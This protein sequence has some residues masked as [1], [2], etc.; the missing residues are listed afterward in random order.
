MNEILFEIGT[1]EIPSGYIAPAAEA[2]LSNVCGRLDKLSISYEDPQW[3]ATPRRLAVS[4]MG[5]PE[6]RPVKV[7]KIFGPPRKSAFNDDGSLSKAGLGFAKSKGVEPGAVKVEQTDKGEYAYV[8]IDSG[9]ELCAALM[10]EELPKAAME[11]PFPKS[12]AWGDYGFRFTRPIH[13]VV[14]VFG[15]K[16]IPFQLGHIQTGAQTRGHRFLG[17]QDMQVTGRSDY[18]VHL[19][20]AHVVA[21]LEKRKKM[22]MD[23]ARAVASAHAATLVED[24]DLAHTI[25]CLVEWP[26]ALWGS[27]DKAY[28]ALPEELLIASMKNHQ[29]MF[30]V[31]DSAGKLTNGFVGVSNMKVEDEQVVVSGYQRVLR[32]RLADAKFFFDEDL[33]KPLESFVA[34]LDHVVYQ[35]KLGTIGQKVKRFTTMAGKIAQIVDPAL[36]KNVNRAAHLCKADLE[37]L[38]VYEFPELQGVVGREYARHAGE[39]EEVCMA[40]NESYMPRFSGDKTA[41]GAVGAIVGIADRIDTLTGCFGIG[42][43][44]TGTQDPFA[45]RRGALGVIQTIL[46]KGYRISLT[47]LISTSIGLYDGKLQAPA[48]EVE[49]KLIEFFG[50]R[51]KHMWARAGVGHDV[52]EAVLSSGIDDIVSARMR[53]EALTR[54]KELPFFIPLVTTYKRAANIVKGAPPQEVDPELFEKEAE[55]MLYA[56]VKGLGQEAMELEKDGYFF[57]ALERLAGLR[58]AV[59]HL[60]DEVMIMAEDKKVRNNRLNLLSQVTALFMQIADFSKIEG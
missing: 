13:W 28:L 44:P 36:E 41:S 55:R 31:R 3:Y 45:L 19:S 48:E 5:L 43:I 35:K 10:A 57:E 58:S 29:K 1:E 49:K 12:M 56:E 16:I 46:D 42:L 21:D 4:I 23:Q 40:I 38:M 14:A 22:V 34:R 6:K 17:A 2:L 53:L 32:A 18:L 24:E 30:S 52:A 54:L 8:E 7:E 27:F 47:D 39:P 26:T 37:T 50:A 15:G 9:G 25:A 59:D 11:I 33:K 60:F 51:L 20:N